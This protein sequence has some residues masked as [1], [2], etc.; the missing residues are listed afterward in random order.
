MHFEYPLKWRVSHGQCHVKL[1]PS[2]R[3]FCAHYI[4]IH[5]FAVSLHSKPHTQ[6]ECGISWNLPPALWAELSGSFMCYTG[7]EQQPM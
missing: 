5:L 7:V 4:T 2:W 1:P 3:A 6:E